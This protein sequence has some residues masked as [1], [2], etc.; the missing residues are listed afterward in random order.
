M[1]STIVPFG[2]LL[3][4]LVIDR[5]TNVTDSF[6]YEFRDN[7]ANPLTHTIQMQT[8]GLDWQARSAN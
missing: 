1:S 6:F 2:Y 5:Q 4:H 8:M 7:S 3:P